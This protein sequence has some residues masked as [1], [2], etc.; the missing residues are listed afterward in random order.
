VG[1]LSRRVAVEALV[2]VATVL[3]LG[4]A[5]FL[6]VWVPDRNLVSTAP[7]DQPNTETTA[8]ME[9]SVAGPI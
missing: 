1:V 6:L 3:Q 4:L 8:E 2:G 9:H 5:V 7:R